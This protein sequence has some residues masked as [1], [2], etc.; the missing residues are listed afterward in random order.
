MGKFVRAATHTVPFDGD[1][2]VFTVEA[3]KRRHLMVLRPVVKTLQD[4]MG[5]DNVVKMDE[6]QA[7]ALMDD[8]VPVIKEVVSKVEGGTA[9]DG[10]PITLNDI[11][12]NV[13]FFPLLSQ[14]S[15]ML[16]DGLRFGEDKDDADIEKAEAAEEVAVK[17]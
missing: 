10:T 11:C 7:L 8:L 13:Y 14:A 16:M 3:L 15:V 9:E 4:A 17:N 5:E 2:Y 1:T 12:D 6:D